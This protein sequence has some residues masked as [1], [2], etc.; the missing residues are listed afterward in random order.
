M[1][2]YDSMQRFVIIQIQNYLGLNLIS[3]NIVTTVTGTTFFSP[4][5]LLIITERIRHARFYGDLFLNIHEV[6]VDLL[7]ALDDGGVALGVAMPDLPGILLGVF[8]PLFCGWLM[9][10]GDDIWRTQ[11]F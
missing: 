1:R 10:N 4:R 2:L 6:L 11:K 5:N 3:S 9:V 8:S 7:C